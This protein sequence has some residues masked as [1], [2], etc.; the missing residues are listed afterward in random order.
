MDRIIDITKELAK[1]T[2]LTGE[3]TPDSQNQV[4]RTVKKAT[5]PILKK[6]ASFKNENLTK[7]F[8][9]NDLC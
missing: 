8:D 3:N 6:L 5:N 7:K 9:I 2:D 4:Q 1:K